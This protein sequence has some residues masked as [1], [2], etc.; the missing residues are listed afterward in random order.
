MKENRQL[1]YKEN[2]DSS[3][4]LKTVSAFANYGGGSIVFGVK[5]NGTVTGVE[6]AHSACLNLENR[7]N[8]S[9]HPVPD[10]SLEIRDDSTIW[11]T[12]QEGEFKPY[13]YRGRAYKRHDTAT[14]EVERLELSRLILEGSG[15]TF[16]ELPAADQNLTFSCLEGEFKDAMGIHSLNQDILKTLALYSDKTGY[17]NAA[18]LLADKNGFRGT[19]IVRFGDSLNEILYH[20]SLEG[21]SILGQFH[22]SIHTFL[23]FYRYEKIEGT[24]RRT[25]DRIPEKAFRE[26]LAN[27]L[28][29]RTWDVNASIK[30]SM[31]QDR[32]EISSPGGL[33]AGISEE[34]YLNGHVSILRN[35]ILGNVFF[36]L[37]YIE[38]FGTGILRIRQEYA[39]SQKKPAFQVFD[40]SI[41]V[42]LPI[43]S[44]QEKLTE[45][46]RRI[47]DA[48]EEKGPLSRSGLTEATGLE[49]S[50]LLRLL[51]SML[52]RSIIEREGK[53]RA[54]KYRLPEE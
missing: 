36:R 29:H 7:I 28:I 52:D 51:N 24:E 46:E 37:N 26:A 34:E 10:Y 45:P 50:R 15:R 39:K 6:N 30:V 31:F 11:L 27:A 9:I 20:E 38:K 4:F 22:Q 33:P 18:A 48:L 43:F 19:E 5:D 41:L 53:G 16:E 3:T 17:N 54:V 14:V 49:K 13:L 2:P 44:S 40:N 21:C 25:I 35:P 32:V 1:E 12:V 8:D 47:V 23:T 42:V